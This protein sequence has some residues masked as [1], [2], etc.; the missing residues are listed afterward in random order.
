[1]IK[2]LENKIR[3]M[4]GLGLIGLSLEIANK[5][6]QGLGLSDSIKN[7]KLRLT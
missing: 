4:R 1:M 3:M 2:G 5:E 6:Y 7:K